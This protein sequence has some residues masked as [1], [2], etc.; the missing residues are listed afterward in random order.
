MHD[1]RPEPTISIVL[2]HAAVALVQIAQ[3]IKQALQRHFDVKYDGSVRTTEPDESERI[4]IGYRLSPLPDER[5]SGFELDERVE[6]HCDLLDRMNVPNGCRAIAVALN[7][8]WSDEFRDR[9]GQAANPSTVK[10]WRT[11]RRAGRCGT[12]PQIGPAAQGLTDDDRMLR[13]LRRHHAIRTNA[14]GSSIRDGYLRALNDIGRVNAGAH[15]HYKQPACAIRP[16]SYE[17]FRRDCRDLKVRR[18]SRQ[19][20]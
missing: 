19:G 18:S 1:D 7:D 8:H 3:D 6:A 16:F 11:G 4:G 9:F 13:G 2:F 15:A 14:S 17:T 10:G 12:N 5:Q 20:R